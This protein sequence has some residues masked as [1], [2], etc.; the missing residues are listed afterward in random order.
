M[1][2]KKHKVSIWFTVPLPDVRYAQQMVRELE[3]RMTSVLGC[4][5]AI[6]SDIAIVRRSSKGQRRSR[7]QAKEVQA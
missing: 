4:D 6:N 5:V 7:T 3:K 1:T 2:L